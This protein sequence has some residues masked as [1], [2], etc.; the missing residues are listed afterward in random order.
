MDINFFME[1]DFNGNSIREKAVGGTES[2]L[3]YM[4]REL[5]LLGHS[6]VAYTKAPGA[7]RIDGVEYR[8]MRDLDFGSSPDV[9]VSMRDFEVLKFSNARL[10]VYWIQDAPDQPI[11]QTRIHDWPSADMIFTVSSWQAGE[12]MRCY[13]MPRERL[14]VTRNGVDKASF[15]GEAPERTEGRLVYASAPYRG[16]E[17]LLEAFP[18]IRK[19]VPGAELRICGE[20]AGHVGKDTEF[21]AQL[22][23]KAREL[24]ANVTGGLK[25]AAFIS[26][27]M[28]SSVMAYPNSFAE[29]S[30]IAALESQAAGT[31]LVTTA[32]GALPETVKGGILIEGNGRGDDYRKRFVR[33]VASL[34]NDRQRW[35][36]LSRAGREH[37]L[38]RHTWD[39]IAGEWEQKFR[40]A[41]EHR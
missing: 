41:L 7:G 20:L 2:A 37:V 38:S 26:E 36:E 40:Q 29:T 11:V 16:L 34:L 6:V 23:E 15:C 4:A 35:Q 27:L 33:E 5:A 18:E 19:L 10:K 24:G 31:P 21:Y 17:T 39:M 14:F 1:S 3:I 12:F 32:L 13:N 25:K 9:L 28:S 30:C 22:Y 8:N